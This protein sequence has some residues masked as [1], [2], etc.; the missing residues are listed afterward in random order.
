MAA[1]LRNLLWPRQKSSAAA[2]KASWD[3]RR[4]WTAL[5][6][7]NHGI[8]AALFIIRS[9]FYTGVGGTDRPF[10][11]ESFFLG[12]LCGP[13]FMLPTWLGWDNNMYNQPAVLAWVTKMNSASSGAF[14]AWIANCVGS[15]A[16]MYLYQI[17]E[18]TF[19]LMIVAGGLRAFFHRTWPPKKDSAMRLYRWGL[20]LELIVMDIAYVTAYSYLP[21]LSV[22]G[23]WGLTSIMMIIHHLNVVPDV[24]SAWYEWKASKADKLSD[25]SEPCRPAMA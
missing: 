5:N 21:F 11:F 18:G 8:Y 17:A 24:A 23:H 16:F 15:P 7:A 4:T 19:H 12:W 6:V 14:P 1:G 10:Y 9:F 20:W 25:K 3:A 13:S 22:P 2:G